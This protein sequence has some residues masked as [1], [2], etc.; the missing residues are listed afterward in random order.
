[1]TE[2]VLPAANRDF[3]AALQGIQSTPG[4]WAV[5]GGL[6][7]WCH[8]GRSHRPTLDIDT[9]A[10]P[11]ARETLVAS[12]EPGDAD[13]RRHIDGVK[14]ELIDVFD[15]SDGLA[16]LTNEQQLF[17]AGHWAAAIGATPVT[18]CSGELTA[19]VP[20]AP[21][22][23]LVS[24]KLHAWLGRRPASADKRGS[25]GL[26]IVRLLELGDWPELARQL[27]P[28]SGLAVVTAWAA[29][30]VLVDQATRVARL[31]SVNTDTAPMDSSRITELGEALVDTCQ[32]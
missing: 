6:A 23:P 11:I 21:R 8:L 31:I 26:D 14:L 2:L 16:D 7:V 18:I 30:A 19:I 25:D 17:V 20:V 29:R 9:A 3:V 15:P 1:M 10:G 24:C 27:D 13:H 28:G 5:V 4:T 12:G 32:S 22:G